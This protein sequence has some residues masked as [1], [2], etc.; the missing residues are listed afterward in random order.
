MSSPEVS[1]ET[2]VNGSYSVTVP[3]AIRSALDVQPG[4]TLRWT[5]TDEGELQVSVVEQEH[6]ALS[7]LDPVDVG[8]ATDAVELEDEFGSPNGE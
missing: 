2:T 8:S 3:A 4:D 7:A 6:G 5:L 1:D